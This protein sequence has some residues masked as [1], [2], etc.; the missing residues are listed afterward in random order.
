MLQAN[1]TIDIFD[2]PFFVLYSYNRMKNKP[3]QL[4]VEH[5]ISL[6][7]RMISYS[8]LGMSSEQDKLTQEFNRLFN[9][10][11]KYHPKHLHLIDLN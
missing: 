4:I 3:S 5:M 1:F 7:E 2:N 8:K 9:W 11:K 10:L 6:Q